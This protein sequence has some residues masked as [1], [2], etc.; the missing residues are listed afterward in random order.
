[1]AASR[2]SLD[3]DLPR[4]LR[5]HQ[6]TSTVPLPPTDFPQSAEPKFSGHLRL[7]ARLQSDGRTSLAKQSFRAPFHISKPYWDGRVLQ[8]RVINSTAGI[9]SGDRLDLDV[10]TESGASLLVATPAATRAFVMRSGAAECSQ[11]FAVEPGA[12]LEYS[13]EPLF[14]HR[15]TNYVQDTRIEVAEGGELCFADTL[16]PG[17]AGRGEIWAWKRLQIALEVS[18]GG[19][20]LLRERFDG[21]GPDLGRLASHHGMPEAW[22]ATVIVISP[23]LEAADPLWARIRAL[24]A[25]Q[26]RVGVTRLRNSAWV[27]RIIATGSQSLRDTLAEIRAILGEKLASLQSDLRRI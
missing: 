23:R 24:H 10:R 8:V 19:E 25:K 6:P 16:A 4:P 20:I 14:P 2:D 9:L 21:A 26:R 5:P 27:V 13:P 15:D 17:R 1:M 3:S 22:F 18:I 7:E 12:W 11:R